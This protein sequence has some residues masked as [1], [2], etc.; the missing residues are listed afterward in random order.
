MTRT[1]TEELSGS[2]LLPIRESHVRAIL[3]ARYEEQ[4][5][6]S[7]TAYD[8]EFH[9]EYRLVYAG[10]LT[11]TTV[12][13]FF[14]FPSNLE[15]LHEVRFLVDDVEPSEVSYTMSGIGWNTT[16]EA[17]KE[18][19]ISISYQADGANSFAYAL[20][21]NQRS[22]VDVTFTVVG[23]TGSEVPQWSLPSTANELAEEGE[24]FTW[25]YDNLIANRNIRL[26]LPSRLSFAQRVAKLQDDFL[27]LAI[28]APFLVGLAL[29]SLSALCHLSDVR[30]QLPSYLLTGLGLA[31]FYPLLTFLSG[32]MD[33]LLAALLALLLVS[34]LVVLF[35]RR[36]TGR[37]QVGW[38]VVWLLAIFLGCFSLGTLTPWRGLLMTVGSLLFVGGFMLLYARRPPALEPAPVPEPLA[39]VPEFTPEPELEPEP[40]PEPAGYHCPR[41]GLALADDYHFCPGCGYETESFSLCVHCGYKQFVSAGLETGHCLRCGQPLA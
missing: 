23:L 12:E 37:R 33:V 36:A 27:S 5:G 26:V 41:C 25:D 31:L 21:Q 9:G 11:T 6:V 14:P 7:V 8:L 2:V 22:D 13:L 38:G 39:A 19:Q 4:E 35:L 18:R 34:A 29:V 17:G 1:L 15:T 32:L 16:L 30:L 24:S 10:P 28:L 3:A 40:E 20:N